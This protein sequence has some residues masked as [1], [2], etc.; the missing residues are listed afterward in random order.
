MKISFSAGRV[1]PFDSL[2]PN[3]IALDGACPGPQVDPE[4]RRYSFDHHEGCIRLVTSATCRQ[5][6]DALLLGLDPSDMTVLVNDVD[7]DTVLSVWLLLHAGLLQDPLNRD[8]L[9]TLVQAVAELDAHGPSYPVSRPDMTWHFFFA[10]PGA[11][12]GGSQVWR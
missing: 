12:E 8:R 5:V 6:F 3:T 4:N 2:P 11:G 1:L 10:N 9:R 7:G